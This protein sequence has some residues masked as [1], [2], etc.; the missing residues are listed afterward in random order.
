V[1]G[2]DLHQLRFET[3]LT[4]EDAA[5]LD[6]E[7]TWSRSTSDQMAGLQIRME[8]LVERGLKNEARL[9]ANSAVRTAARSSRR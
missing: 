8:E 4:T 3:A 5:A 2:P 6:K 9:S 7:E 1:D